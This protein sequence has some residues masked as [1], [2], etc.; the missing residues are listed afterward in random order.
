MVQKNILAD[1]ITSGGLLLAV[2]A[3]KAGQ[4]LTMLKQEGI[5]EAAIIG[6]VSAG[7]PRIIVSP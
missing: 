4:L 1:P 5:A 6:R 2:P 3:E 7:D